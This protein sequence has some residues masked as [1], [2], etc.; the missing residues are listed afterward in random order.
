MSKATFTYRGPMKAKDVPP[1][2]VFKYAGNTLFGQT[3]FIKLAARPNVVN[4]TSW[5]AA[6][7]DDDADVEILGSLSLQPPSSL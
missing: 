5:H 6:T 7:V 3:E 1:G 4:T 2:K